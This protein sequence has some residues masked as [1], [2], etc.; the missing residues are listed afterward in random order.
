MISQKLGTSW[1]A[2]TWKNDHFIVG[3]GKSHYEAI[4]NALE[5]LSLQDN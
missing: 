2:W 5:S 3:R 4:T 1:F